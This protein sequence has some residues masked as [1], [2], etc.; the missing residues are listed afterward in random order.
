MVNTKATIPLRVGEQR[1]IFTAT[2][3]VFGKNLPPFTSPSGDS[4]ILFRDSLRGKRRKKTIEIYLP[5]KN[6][7]VLKKTFKCV[8]AF[9]IELIFGNVDF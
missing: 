7:R 6:L 9:Q 3:H 4:C 5:T 1:S 2:L 8:R